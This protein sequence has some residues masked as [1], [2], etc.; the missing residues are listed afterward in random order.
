MLLFMVT[1]P[2]VLGKLYVYDMN[3]ERQLWLTMQELTLSIVHRC[4]YCLR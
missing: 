3:L 1:V 2:G 4:A